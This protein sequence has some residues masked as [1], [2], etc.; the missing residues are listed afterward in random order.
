MASVS[1]ADVVAGET[2]STASDTTDAVN[3]AAVAAIDSNCKFTRL[4]N[5]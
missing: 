3:T 5:L 1:G 2:A 4:A